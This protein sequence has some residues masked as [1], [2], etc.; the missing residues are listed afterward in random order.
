LRLRKINIA[1]LD[2]FIL[3]DDYLQYGTIPIT[4]LRAFSQVKN[5]KAL[6]E[7]VVLTLAISDEGELDGFIGALPDL[8]GNVHC[9]W[10]SCWWVKEGTPAEVSMKLFFSFLN[11]WDR[12]VLFSELTPHT[13]NLIE[14]LRFCDHRS[15]EGLR[16]YSRFCLADILPRKKPFFKKI[17]IGL[18]IFDSVA[19]T[20]VSGFSYLFGKRS[21]S[22]KRLIVE[23]IGSFTADLDDFVSQFNQKQPAKRYSENF[24]WIKENP[25]VEVK[26][27]AMPGITERY[28]FSYAVERF[29]LQWVKFT[30]ENE[31][32]GLVCY[33]IRDKEL[34]LCYAF[35]WEKY[36]DE[37]GDY[38]Y[39]M[40]QSDNKLCSITTFH[41]GL[42]KYLSSRKFLFKT[43]L[44]KPT[45]ISNT[46]IEEASIIDF[47]LQMGDG[48]C[49]FT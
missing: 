26:Q 48:D 36:I 8:V 11:D 34:K 13:S 31:L 23:K 10:N 41:P 27:S 9:A 30:F 15:V 6:P 29:E 16:G 12:K 35:T 4:P 37:I 5:P 7:D 39:I 32:I 20:S 28:P 47:E 33:S 18:R 46:L 14:H 40:L 3:S 38:F 22:N 49:I 44:P 1:Q 43:N 19:N 17:R 42:A 45:A 21:F 24:N 25:W 2:Q